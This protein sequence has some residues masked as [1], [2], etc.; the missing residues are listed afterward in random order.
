MADRALAPP[1]GGTPPAD[2]AIVGGESVFLA[3][4][5]RE[6]AQRHWAEFP[7]EQERYG[8]A[9]FEWCVH[10]LQYVLWWAALDAR[11]DA[12]L[13]ERQLTWLAAVLAARGY[14]VERLARSLELTAGVVADRH[15]ATGTAVTKTLR[16]Q[17]ERL[18]GR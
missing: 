15:A 2:S 14:P 3:P 10:D 11:G 9:G 8:D 13:L 7:E 18:R 4:L 6:A 12:G 16:T 17:A 5:A 1:R